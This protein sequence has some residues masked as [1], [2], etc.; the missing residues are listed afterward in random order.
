MFCSSS[1]TSTT[2]RGA[3]AASIADSVY[4]GAV[5]RG[6]SRIFLT[7]SE[8]A[9]SEVDRSVKK[10]W[11]PLPWFLHNPDMGQPLQ[12]RPMSYGQQTS[13]GSDRSCGC[14][15]GRRPLLL[16]LAQSQHG[17]DADHR[18]RYTRG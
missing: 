8:T 3:V 11:R 10:R 15:R 16:P 2:G 12:S 14:A 5:S 9:C 1:T 13:A 18:D 7:S 17:L 6:I 4:S